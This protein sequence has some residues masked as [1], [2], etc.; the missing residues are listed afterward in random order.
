MNKRSMALLEFFTVELRLLKN[1][2]EKEAMSIMYLRLV[3]VVV[4][5]VV[6]DDVAVG[7]SVL[8]IG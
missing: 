4:V 5:V 7:Q 8:F 1:E 3:I 6:V 2:E